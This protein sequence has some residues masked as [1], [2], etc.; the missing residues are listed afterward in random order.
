MATKI[1]FVKTYLRS[2]KGDRSRAYYLD[3]S[4]VP[5]PVSLCGSQ[6]KENNLWLVSELQAWCFI[7][8]AQSMATAK[9]Q[10]ISFPTCF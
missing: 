2:K 8:S 9:L 10:G 1:I 3:P 6:I 7:L 5:F 4:T